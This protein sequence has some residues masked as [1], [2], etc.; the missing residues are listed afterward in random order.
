MAERSSV[1]SDLYKHVYSFLL[2]NKFTEAARHFIRQTDV[3]PQDEQE[4]AGLLDIFNFWVKS[5]EA[6]KRK[7]LSIGPETGDRP[8]AKKAKTAESS[9]EES[10]SDEEEAAAPVKAASTAKAP[11]PAESDSSSS[12]DSSDEEEAVA[13]VHELCFTIR[14]L[15]YWVKIPNPMINDRVQNKLK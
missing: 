2:E 6:K 4:D 12:D 11:R 9:S 10:S 5:P 14:L 7:A 13:K 3:P 15:F 8:S 1:P